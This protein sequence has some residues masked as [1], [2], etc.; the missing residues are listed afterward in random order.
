[1]RFS[2]VNW[3]FFASFYNQKF[4]YWSDRGVNGPKPRIIFGNILDK[5]FGSRA[6]MDV[7]YEKKYGK[8]FG[9][10]NGPIPSLF[11]ME[12]ELIKNVMVKDFHC[13]MERP[14]FRV[15]HEM[16]KNNLLFSQNE[17]WKRMRTITSP[18]FTSGKLRAMIPL[19]E[20]CVD[21]FVRFLDKKVQ[22]NGGVINVKEVT[23]GFTIDVIASTSFA[24]DTNANEEGEDSVLVKQGKK[25]FDVSF[26]RGFATF[27]FPVPILKLLNIKTF[28]DPESFEFFINLTKEIVKKRKNENFKRNDLVQLMMD[29]YVDENELNRVNFDQL[30]ASLDEGNFV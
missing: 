14:N 2:D 28:N 22:N 18:S 17:K 6:E 21:Q 5:L 1:M 4:K 11:I 26:F 30:T 7:E 23:T 19:M 20:K 27:V 12:S 29:A 9:Y 24:T 15:I 13:F 8:L 10:Y 3:L 25:F 16:M